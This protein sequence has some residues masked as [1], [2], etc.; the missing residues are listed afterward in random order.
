MP[1]PTPAI[2]TFTDGIVANAAGLNSLGLNLA[3]LY[4]YTMG[5]FRTLKPQCAV[6]VNAAGQ[7]IPTAT[8]TVISFDIADVNTDNM[9]NNGSPAQ[10]VVQTAGTYFLYAQSV[11]QGGFS[12]FAVRIL[13]NGTALT[14][15]VGSFS[16]S[17]NGGNVS[18]LVPLAAGA[19]I[20]ASIL[21][22]TGGAVSLATGLGSSRLFAFFV[23]P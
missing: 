16:A 19:T 8:E 4:A 7:S 9:W 21:Q 20:A 14:N 5:G 12:T 22:S 6:R 3:N 2:S 1:T 15:S 18:A 10:M 17:A 13:V 11:H 23:S